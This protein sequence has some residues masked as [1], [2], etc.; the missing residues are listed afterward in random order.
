MS[1]L[2]NKEDLISRINSQASS[3]MTID[4]TAKDND[5]MI[6]SK[7]PTSGI[8]Q[9]WS[10]SDMH[11]DSPGLD[12]DNSSNTPWS[13]TFITSFLMRNR[14]YNAISSSL[15]G[16]SFEAPTT[17]LMGHDSL[18]PPLSNLRS[19][20]IVNNVF[21]IALFAL[22]ISS[23]KAISAVGRNPDVTL[24]YSSFSRD[25]RDNGPNNSS[26][27][28][29]RV[30][31]RWKNVPSHS[32]ASRRPKIDFPVPGFPN[33]RMCSF[34]IIAKTT[35]RASSPLSTNPSFTLATAAFRCLCDPQH[36]SLAALS[37]TSFS[38][39]Q[40]FLSTASVA[41]FFRIEYTSATLPE[42]R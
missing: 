36:L 10:L 33:K 20:K 29:K 14:S 28:V 2:S 37:S 39:V 15:S 16:S 32:F 11:E 30:R 31:S 35:R 34:A 7:S 13:D 3:S 18:L 38:S 22:K 25:F 9:P 23:R 41:S 12:I 8:S 1:W 4:S 21:K 6:P 26:G 40:R 19:F 27:V 42:K 17:H 24:R 5:S